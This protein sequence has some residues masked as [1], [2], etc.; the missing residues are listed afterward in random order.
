MT[1]DMIAFYG[2]GVLMSMVL[3]FVHRSFMDK[4]D[5]CNALWYLPIAAFSWGVILLGLVLI[6]REAIAERKGT[7]NE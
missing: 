6:L 7:K 2:A 1:E 5:R 4:D 3:F